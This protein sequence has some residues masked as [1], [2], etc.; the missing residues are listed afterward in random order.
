F[1]G[2]LEL[3]R[4]IL[5][6]ISSGLVVM[7]TMI[8]AVKLWRDHLFGFTPEPVLSALHKA[9]Y[10]FYLLMDIDLPWEDDELRDFPNL[11]EH[12]K[13]VWIREL[14]ALGARYAI[15]KGIGTTRLLN[16]KSETECFLR[17]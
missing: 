2:Q 5:T 8:L 3:E 11:R 6:G 10:D 9:H 16:A 1:H 17:S 12:F 13:N 14:S 4:Q 15:V 7:D